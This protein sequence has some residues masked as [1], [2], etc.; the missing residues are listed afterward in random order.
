MAMNFFEA[1]QQARSRTRLLVFLFAVAVLLLV[2]LTDLVV[3]IALAFLQADSARSG[4]TRAVPLGLSG[5]Q[6]PG[7]GCG[8]RCCGVVPAIA[9][10][11]RRQSGG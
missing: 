7:S 3:L 9:A 10:E 2:A 11:K 6:Q 4:R 8:H 1:Q 5:S